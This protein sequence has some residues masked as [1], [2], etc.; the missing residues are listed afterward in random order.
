[1][2]ETINGLGWL[3][4]SSATKSVLQLITTSVLARIISPKDFGTVALAMTIIHFTELLYQV[5]VAPALVQRKLISSRHVSS[6][7]AF[8]V[9][10]G[11]ILS[12]IFFF[13]APFFSTYFKMPDLL[14]VIRA[15][16]WIFPIKSFSQISYALLQRKLNFKGIA[17]LDVLSYLFGYGICG[18][19]LAFLDYGIWS[20]VFAL[21]S[22]SI[23][24]SILLYKASPYPL[25][26][27]IHK[28]ESK[29]LL[30]FG[31]A[32]TFGGL[33]N[34][35]ALKADY[36]IIGKYL[37]PSS[38]AFYSRAY[39]IMNIPNQM[40]G[41]AV[42]TV[43]FSIFS[44]SKA[45]DAATKRHLLTSLFGVFYLIFPVTILVYGNAELLVY[46]LLGN[47]WTKAI[48]PLKILVLGMPFRLSYKIFGDYLKSQNI[49]NWF[50]ASQITYALLVIFGALIG[51]RHGLGIVAYWVLAAIITNFLIMFYAVNS[52]LG[53]IR[54]TS[55][56]D[57]LA[58]SNVGIVT[59]LV[60]KGVQC[61]EVLNSWHPIFSVVLMLIS[62]CLI[63]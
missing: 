28:K 23:L 17:G 3:M 56:N 39:A 31:G 11:S 18:L 47:D 63:L 8:S 9:L 58:I 22:Q 46:A 42:S 33:I 55:L 1:M 51:V 21:L 38:L 54:E 30:S 36:K 34:F 41:K 29:E 20:L 59:F 32:L 12:L 14:S 15:L 44:H 49:M 16:A 13:V 40:V 53:F 57:A 61:F 45:N 43:L 2:R 35:I 50:I 27:K 60:L 26:F 37:G 62:I 48:L 7:L 25:T 10:L 4:S 5:G 24:Y 6:A 19:S 52:R